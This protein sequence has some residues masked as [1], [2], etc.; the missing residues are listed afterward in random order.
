VVSSIDI[1]MPALGQSVAEGTVMKWLKKPG[2]AVARDESLVAISTDKAETE[3]PAPEAGTLSEILVPE[4]ATVEV[5][6]VLGR[7]AASAGARPAATRSSAASVLSVA[8]GVAAPAS[9]RTPRLGGSFLSPAVRKL[10]RERG[11]SAAAVQALPGTGR[12][13][14]VTLADLMRHLAKGGATPETDD[15]FA[16]VP[17]TGMRLRIAEHMLASKRNA[18]HVNTVAEIDCSAMVAARK[19]LGPDFEK[20]HGFGLS[21]NAFLLRA[22]AAAL[23]EWP[24]VNAILDERGIVQHRR[25]HLGMAVALEPAGLVVPVIHDAHALTLDEIAVEAHRLAERA[26][27]RQ[28]LPEEM[29]GG[30]CTMTNPGVFGNLFGTPIIHQPQ[31]AIIDF[32]AIKKHAVVIQHDGADVIA[33]RPTCLVVLAW[34]HRILDGA[35][36]AKFLQRLV[37]EVEEC[38]AS[39]GR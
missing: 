34:D 39:V 31:A 15:A 23:A 38:P 4:G 35:T 33:I 9:A 8:A 28:L 25:V 37:R 3:V 21:F 22:C 24:Q 18:P 11:V 19:A 10:A 13:A 20:R 1:A 27:Q 12:N 36:A 29:T 14:R 17:M 16:I 26:R 6:T 5:G 7:I 30:T 2:E 32:G